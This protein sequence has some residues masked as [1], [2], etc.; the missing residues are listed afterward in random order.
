[1]SDVAQH[2]QINGHV[3]NGHLPNVPLDAATPESGGFDI[4]QILWR[5]KWLPIMGSVIGA[6]LGFLYF[7]RQPAEYEA[8]ALVQVMN[9]IAAPSSTKIFDPFDTKINRVDESMVIRSQAVLRKAVQLGRL[10]EQVDFLGLQPD[11]VVAELM[12]EESTLTIEPADKDDNTTLITISY[13][14]EDADVAAKVVTSI[15]EGYEVYLEE[16]SKTVGDEIAKLIGDAHNELYAKVKGLAEESREHQQRNSGV[17]WSGDEFT[18][19]YA[20]AFFSLSKKIIDLKGERTKL[21]N[22]ARQARASQKAGREPASI[23]LLLAQNGAV[24]GETDSPIA[25]RLLGLDEPDAYQT[26]NTIIQ[27]RAGYS[28]PA[29][30]KGKSVA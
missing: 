15:V 21:E 14:S 2:P 12:D 26:D 8:A 20:E 3:Q 16:E 23:L 19:P 7:S 11:D 6:G 22:V 5:W 13:I 24:I 30:G 4:V 18:D 17:V 9:S 28:R 10:T 25:T 29:S 1:M 27:A